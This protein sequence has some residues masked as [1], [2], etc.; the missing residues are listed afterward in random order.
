MQCNI[1]AEA[2]IS[3]ATNPQAN[4]GVD[5]MHDWRSLSGGCRRDATGKAFNGRNCRDPDGDAVREIQRQLEYDKWTIQ[6][7]KRNASLYEQRKALQRSTQ[8][9]VVSSW[10]CHNGQAGN[11]VATETGIMVPAREP[12]GQ[13]LASASADRQRKGGGKDKSAAGRGYSTGSRNQGKEERSE[14]RYKTPCK[15]RGCKCFSFFSFAPGKRGFRADRQY[16]NGG[17]KQ[18]CGEKFDYSNHTFHLLYPGYARG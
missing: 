17:G 1:L 8:Q 4:Y 15:K 7:E 11:R 9:A 13:R 5:P 6:E 3:A 10:Q 16:C 12:T 14:F 2:G 18:W